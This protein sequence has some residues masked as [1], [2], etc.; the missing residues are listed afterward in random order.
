[1]LNLWFFGNKMIMISEVFG[2]ILVY[3]L[4]I[5]LLYSILNRVN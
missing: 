3:Q 5:K 1:M 4:F 2:F